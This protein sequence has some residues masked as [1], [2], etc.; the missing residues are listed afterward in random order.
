MYLRLIN[1][2]VFN[3]LFLP[4]DN[5]DNSYISKAFNSPIE[6]YCFRESELLKFL[7]NF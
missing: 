5:S 2:D 6:K 1:D 4:D 7:T 3:D